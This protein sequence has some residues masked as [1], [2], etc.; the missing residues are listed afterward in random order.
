VRVEILGSQKCR[1]VGKSQSVLIVINPIIFTHTRRPHRT[2]V[3]AVRCREHRAGRERKEHSGAHSTNDPGAVDDGECVRRH[4]KGRRGRARPPLPPPPRHPW[5]MIKVRGSVCTHATSPKVVPVTQ[6]EA[7][8][9]I[10]R[11]VDTAHV[12]ATITAVTVPTV[13]T[14]T[15]HHNHSHHHHYHL[16][17][18]AVASCKFSGVSSPATLSKTI[19][20]SRPKTLIGAKIAL[21]FHSRCDHHRDDADDAPRAQHRRRRCERVLRVQRQSLIGQWG[22]CAQLKLS[23]PSHPSLLPVSLQ[24]G[25]SQRQSA[26]V[27]VVM[28]HR[29]ENHP[30]QHEAVR[31]C[32]GLA[33][34]W[35]AP[36]PVHVS[37]RHSAV[38]GQPSPTQPRPAPVSLSPQHRRTRSNLNQAKGARVTNTA[39]RAAHTTT[40]EGLSTRSPASSPNSTA[41]GI[42]CALHENH[43]TLA[44]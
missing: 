40:R 5:H 7:V 39:P 41:C 28:A 33:G 21:R 14:I 11:R 13:T 16:H 17:V 20:L 1:I 25:A 9:S 8:V 18:P 12:V 44:S 42:S 23:C 31:R 2:Y 30:S 34:D 27:A 29:E 35:P 38:S 4:C 19:V 26:T 10:A 32:R 36:V 43:S 6:T 3:G 24:C 37:T 22:E 15:T